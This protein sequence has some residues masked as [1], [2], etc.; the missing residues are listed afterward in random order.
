M[1]SEKASSFL[2][3]TSFLLLLPTAAFA[4]SQTTGRIAGLVKDPSGAVVAQAEVSVTNEATGEER[5]ATSDET[6]S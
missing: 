3:A 4:Q 2:L 5:K 6:G 1:G